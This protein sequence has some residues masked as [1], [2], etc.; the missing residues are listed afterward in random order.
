MQNST[1][2]Q[3]YRSGFYVAKNLT[4]YTSVDFAEALSDKAKSFTFDTC[5]IA[6]YGAQLYKRLLN[7]HAN[8]RL[9]PKNL[10]GQKIASFA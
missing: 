3:F 10:K 7:H 8:I 6:G 1:N 4:N 2:S 9:A 5:Q